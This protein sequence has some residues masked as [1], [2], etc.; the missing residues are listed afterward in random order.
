MVFVVELLQSGKSLSRQTAFFVPTKHLALKDP[1]IESK[2]SLK[3]I[4][5]NIEVSA[6]STA[7][8]VECSLT[9]ADVVFSDNYFDLPAKKK[10]NITA[11]LPSGWD[12]SMAKEAFRVRS[13]FD[14]YK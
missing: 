4:T 8:L 11:P 7:R 13:V 3:D 10:L 2:L 9:G 6:R 1:Q 14:T 12:L 5:L